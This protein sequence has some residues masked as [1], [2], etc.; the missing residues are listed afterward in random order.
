MHRRWYRNSLG[1]LRTAV[2]GFTEA[3]VDFAMHLGDVVDGL[4]RQASGGDALAAQQ[5]SDVALAEALDVFGQ[6]PGRTYHVVGNHCLYNFARPQ[7]FKKYVPGRALPPP[8]LAITVLGPLDP[9][10]TDVV[11]LPRAAG[12]ITFPALP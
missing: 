5:R 8:A 7:L 6:F 11:R 9:H 2:R 12:R 1:L 10:N 3:K 4:Q